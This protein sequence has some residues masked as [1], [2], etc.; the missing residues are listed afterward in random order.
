LVSKIEEQKSARERKAW[1]Q[2]VGHA[3]R[4]GAVGGLYVGRRCGGY[5]DWP[6][7]EPFVVLAP[8]MA[9]TLLWAERGLAT[10][11]RVA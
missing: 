1:H 10:K 5:R 7:L 3:P 9:S 6:R 2:A 8:E 11:R 4:R